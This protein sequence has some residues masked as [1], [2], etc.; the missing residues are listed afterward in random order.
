MNEKNTHGINLRMAPLL[1]ILALLFAQPGMAVP[2]VDEA[3]SVTARITTS[4]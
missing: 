3:P 1:A 4:I 2:R